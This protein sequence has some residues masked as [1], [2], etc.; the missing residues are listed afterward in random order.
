MDFFTSDLNSVETLPRVS[1]PTQHSPST[2]ERSSVKTLTRFPVVEYTISS[3]P[4]GTIREKLTNSFLAYYYLRPFELDH[5]YLSLS[6][7][8]QGKS[9]DEPPAPVPICAVGI[10]PV[11][12]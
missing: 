10:P 8:F 1:R 2:R 3:I 4:R 7:S 6:F 5:G 12:V 9:E 11:A